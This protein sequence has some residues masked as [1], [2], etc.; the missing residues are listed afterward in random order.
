MRPGRPDSHSDAGFTLI[1]VLLVIALIGLLASMAFPSLRRAQTA[2]NESS[3]IGSLRTIGNAQQAYWSS[4][5][6]GMYAPSL[7]ELGVQVGNVPGYLGPDLSGPVPVLKSGYEFDVGYDKVSQTTSCRNGAT[8]TGYHATAD[9]QVGR[10]R[11]YFGLNVMGSIFQS[12][13]TLFGVMTDAAVP[14]S[15]AVPVASH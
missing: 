9:P 14:P 7:Q 6:G 2:A 12:T 15:P 1:E 5:G 11:R 13:E 8:V 3:A 10:G 4:C